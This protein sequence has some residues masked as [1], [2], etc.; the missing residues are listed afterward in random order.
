MT[1]SVKRELR[2]TA[3]YLQKSFCLE[4]QLA[5]INIHVNFI[6]P[7]FIHFNSTQDS[8]ACVALVGRLL[9]PISICAEFLI[10][11]LL[12]TIYDTTTRVGP[13]G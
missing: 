4:R 2:T 6:S 9:A 5:D 1:M 11:Q 13:C 10:I 3:G 12:N 8:L 7:Y